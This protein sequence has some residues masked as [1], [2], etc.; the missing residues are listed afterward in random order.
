[1]GKQS[2]REFDLII[3]DQKTELKRSSYKTDIVEELRDYYNYYKSNLKAQMFKKM[4][5]A[6]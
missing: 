5:D 2:N 3:N 4:K 6:G 1:M